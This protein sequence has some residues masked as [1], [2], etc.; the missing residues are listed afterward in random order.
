MITLE[1]RLDRKLV[2]SPLMQGMLPGRNPTIGPNAQED[3]KI[4]HVL[5]LYLDLKLQFCLIQGYLLLRI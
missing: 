1:N 5:P 2:F 4:G 3:Q